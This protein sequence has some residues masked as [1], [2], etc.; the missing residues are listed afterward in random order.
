VF[1]LLR[2]EFSK[3]GVAG[4]DVVFL[5]LEFFDLCLDLE[6]LCLVGLEVLYFGG[7]AGEAGVEVVQ[8]RAGPFCQ[9]G[10]VFVEVVLEKL[11]LEGRVVEQRGLQLRVDQVDEAFLAVFELLA[12]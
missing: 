7:L 8:T 9:R 10:H 12:Q 11:E 1:Q 3:D 6:D 5:L 4:F 2:V